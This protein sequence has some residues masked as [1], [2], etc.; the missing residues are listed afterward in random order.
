MRFEVVVFD[1]DGVLLDTEPLNVE[2]AVAAF[3]WAGHALVPGDA[4]RIIGR[5]PDDYVPEI[6]ARFSMGDAEMLRLREVQER[7]YVEAFENRL[8]MKSGARSALER[9]QRNGVRVGLATSSS[10]SEVRRSFRR[11]DLDPFFEVVLTKDDVRRLKPDPEIYRRAA[12]RLSVSPESML[13]VED[14]EHGIGSAKAA[15][16]FCVALATPEIPAE[17]QARADLRITTFDELD[18]LLDL[19]SPPA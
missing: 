6:G 2:S 17:R 4:L 12:D 15:G 9:L 7:L 14:S 18:E 19:N 16:A 8:A 13:V 3:A 11:F 10:R 1:L 5:H